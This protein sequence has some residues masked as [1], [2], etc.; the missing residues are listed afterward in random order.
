MKALFSVLA[1]LAL[2]FGCA[3]DAGPQAGASQPPG[4]A[5]GE[6]PAVVPYSDGWE[7][8][9][10]EVMDA[11]PVYFSIGQEP[12]PGI[13]GEE[14]S[15]SFCNP[16]VAAP[17]D[18]CGSAEFN[19]NPMLGT[20]PYH[21]QLDSGTG[22]PPMGVVLHPNGL[23]SGKPAAAGNSTFSV[24]AVD[25]AGSSSCNTTSLFVEDAWATVDSVSCSVMY[26][27]AD[28]RSTKYKIIVKGRAYGP[29]GS[30]MHYRDNMNGL[31]EMYPDALIYGD[32]EPG[33][34]C[35]SWEKSNTFLPYCTNVN[36][37]GETQWTVAYHV[38]SGRQGLPWKASANIELDYWHMP[39]ET[40][41]V[42]M[43]TVCN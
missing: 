40:T 26:K 14:Y 25:Q 28:E 23:L 43:E 35:G 34:A 5:G 2:L 31:N 37:A 33:S 4:A 39:G 1:A 16:E 18:I 30:S 8:G 13:I 22:F 19:Y 20:P 9:E 6:G 42:S 29:Q 36:G 15:H 27:F 10:N 41:P 21:F 11:Q 12:R 17:S 32:S 24:C 3:G 38:W 7:P